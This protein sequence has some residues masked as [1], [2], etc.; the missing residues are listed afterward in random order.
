MNVSGHVVDIVLA[1]VLGVAPCRTAVA[2]GP[3]TESNGEPS[4]RTAPIHSDDGETTEPVGGS[5]AATPAIYP[6]PVPSPTTA[7]AP[8]RLSG[9]PTSAPA[10][11]WWQS[12]RPPAPPG[13]HVDP[14]SDERA[15]HAVVTGWAVGVWGG[16]TRGGS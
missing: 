11:P 12:K 9:P 3:T 7:P 13:E 4:H 15:Q 8:L 16:A 2:Q 5:P 10:S 6:E 14:D 1:V